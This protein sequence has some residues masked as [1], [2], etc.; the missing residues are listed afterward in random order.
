M[1]EAARAGGAAINLMADAVG[2]DAIVVEDEPIVIDNDEL[3]VI[4]DNEPVVGTKEKPII[5]YSE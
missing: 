1:K 4:E 3:I 5:E 2:G